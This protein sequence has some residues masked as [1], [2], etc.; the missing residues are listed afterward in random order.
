MEVHE[1]LLNLDSPVCD[2]QGPSD[3]FDIFFEKTAFHIVKVIFTFYKLYNKN[4]SFN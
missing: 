4:Y 2:F 3:S 1:E